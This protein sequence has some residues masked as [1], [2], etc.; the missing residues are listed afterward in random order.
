MA[1][2]WAAIIFAS[3][4]MSGRSDMVSLRGAGRERATR[5]FAPSTPLS[6]VSWLPPRLNLLFQ[7]KFNAASNSKCLQVQENL[8][9]PLRRSAAAARIGTGS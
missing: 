4:G 8:H 7:S 2:M 9:S 6:S 5:A 1:A 3:D